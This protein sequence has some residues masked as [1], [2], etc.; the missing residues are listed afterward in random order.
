[1]IQWGKKWWASGGSGTFPLTF[2]NIYA[3]ATNIGYDYGGAFNVNRYPRDYTTT[4]FSYTY[5][6]TLKPTET[7]WI[8][9]GKGS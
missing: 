3:M 4:G 9:I 2:T 6:S 5:V 7:S 1:M 8:A